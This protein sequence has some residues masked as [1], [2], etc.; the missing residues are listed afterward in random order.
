M[1]A[2]AYTNRGEEVP[3]GVECALPCRAWSPLQ[4]ES[5]TFPA[6]KIE[7]SAAHPLML[8]EAGAFRI[9]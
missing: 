3:L 4:D 6:E 2:G 1:N 8:A 5:G 9:D 7:S